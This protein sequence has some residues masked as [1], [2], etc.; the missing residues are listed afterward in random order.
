MD[1]PPVNK[2]LQLLRQKPPEPPGPITGS[3][4]APHAPN[5]VLPQFL[6]VAYS[7]LLTMATDGY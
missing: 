4:A 5:D 7:M 6:R 2:L 3:Q 1:A